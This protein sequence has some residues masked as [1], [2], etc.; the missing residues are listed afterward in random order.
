[1]TPLKQSSSFEVASAVN[2]GQHARKEGVLGQQVSD[3]RRHRSPPWG[4]Y[5]RLPALRL[6]VLVLGAGVFLLPAGASGRP[7]GVPTVGTVTPVIY[8][9]QGAGGWYVTNVTVNWV[10]TPLPIVMSEGC[11]ARTIATDTVN[12]DLRCTAWWT[13]GFASST[14]HIHRDAT[15]PSVTVVPARSP[16]ANGW[17][18]SPL[19]VTF[20]GSDVTSGIASCTQA[21]YAGPDSPNT[22]VSGSCRDKAGNQTAASF[23]LKYDATAPAL[24]QLRVKPGNRKAH[25]RWN[26]PDDVSAVVLVRS[27]GL[28]G[29]AESVVF[30]GTGLSR[31]YTDRGLRPGR[32]YVYRLTATDAAANAATKTLEFLARGALLFPAPGERVSRPPLLVW[33]P[34]K[35]ASYYNVILSR[36]GRRIYSAWPLRPRLRLPR[37]W[38]YKGRRY[39]LRPGTYSWFV[40][41]GRGPL[42]AGQYGSMLGGSTFTFGGSG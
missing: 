30:R 17:Y 16:D 34:A 38:T 25:L 3:L 28:K 32:N 4:P 6:L 37:A 23:A 8:G 18:N 12:T 10:I 5:R 26:V 33:T 29:A 39:K 20:S 7:A 11:D 40:W 15:P 36:G 1:L 24:G 22:S 31:G 27:P 41:P 2:S 35:G 42:S 19:T 14:V 13:D 9:T 21:A